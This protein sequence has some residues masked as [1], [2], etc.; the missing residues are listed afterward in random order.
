MRSGYMFD[1][2]TLIESHTTFRTLLKDLPLMS[3]LQWTVEV[4]IAYNGN[5]VE[6]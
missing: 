1:P 6:S 5:K 2:S 3:C 4:T